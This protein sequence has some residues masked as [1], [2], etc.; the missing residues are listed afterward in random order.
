[1]SGPR[2]DRPFVSTRM[3][4]YV[5]RIRL[6][7]GCGFVPDPTS[8]KAMR[9]ILMR[10]SVRGARAH[11]AIN[12]LL[13]AGLDHQLAPERLRQRRAT[14]VNA[15]LNIGR[16]ISSLG[17][18]RSRILD[19]PPTSRAVLNK[20]LAAV[21]QPSIFDTETLIEA[22]NAVANALREVSPKRLGDDARSV[23]QPSEGYTSS[24]IVLWELIPAVT[25]VEVERQMQSK[26]PA[27]SLAG[28]LET[29]LK[30]LN[31]KRPAPKQGAPHSVLHE[32]AVRA[33]RIWIRLGLNPGRRYDAR[34]ET[35]VESEFQ[36]FCNL[37]LAAWGDASRL[38]GRQVSNAKEIALGSPSPK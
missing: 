27:D 3:H 16:L 31:Q 6:R 32:F 20:R 36:R 18:L 12:E 24:L 15:R 9:D 37:A 29:L 19:L 7:V 35:P 2:A 14:D 11:K 25:R 17:E 26:Q 21:L 13:Q 10:R 28:W 8:V 22:L 23:I 38:S 33:A 34:R 1:M 30:L 5:H 4:P